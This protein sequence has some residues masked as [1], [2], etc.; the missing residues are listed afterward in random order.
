MTDLSRPDAEF[1]GLTTLVTGGA[2]FIGS[3]IADALVSDNEVRILDDRS[4]GS[5]ENV[6]DGAKL[7]Q[8]DVTNQNAVDRAMKG[9]DVVFHLAAV[10]SVEESVS[11][12]VESHRVNVDGTLAVLEAAR[13][14]SARVVYASS[15][16]VYG[17]PEGSTVSEDDETD[18]QSPYGAD[19]LAADTYVRTY[20]SVYDL[21]AV[22]LRY[23]NVYGPRQQGPYSGVVDAFFE[24]ALEGEPLVI[25]G[26][27]KQTRDFVHVYDVVRANLAAA[28]TEQTGRAFNIGTGRS[29]T[30]QQLAAAVGAAADVDVELEWGPAR[31]GDIRHSRTET[32]RLRRLLGVQPEVSLSEG[33]SD[34]ARYRTESRSRE[35]PRELAEPASTRRSDE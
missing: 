29:V 31:D 3:H 19:K 28:T 22:V 27:G 34:L 33:L 21:P 4:T 12:P 10:V 9:V 5:I 23:F 6:P 1:S 35:T 2:G 7:I 13:R 32:D 15:A 26:D 30:I 25:H 14:E 8:G 11:D 16:A 18:P 17:D 24:R 20:A